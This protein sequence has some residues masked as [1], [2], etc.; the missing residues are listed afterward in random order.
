MSRQYPFERQ[1]QLSQGTELRPAQVQSRQNPSMKWRGGHE[2]HTW[3]RSC[4]HLMATRK[5]RASF[6]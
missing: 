5:G 4:W 2:L 3:L 6:L 1:G